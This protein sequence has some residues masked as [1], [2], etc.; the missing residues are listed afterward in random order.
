MKAS[1]VFDFNDPF[2]SEQRI[3]EEFV[4]SKQARKLKRN[5]KIDL[6][7]E[8]L[9]ARKELAI[10]KI[11]SKNEK[12][13]VKEIRNNPLEG[14]S[15]SKRRITGREFFRA[16]RNRGIRFESAHL[17]LGISKSLLKKRLS[18]QQITCADLMKLVK[19]HLTAAARTAR[20]ALGVSVGDSSW[21]AGIDW[22]RREKDGLILPSEIRAMAGA[23]KAADRS[24]AAPSELIALRQQLCL[25]GFECDRLLGQTENWWG[26]RERGAVKTPRFYL[27]SLRKR[28][29]DELD[30]P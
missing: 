6:F 27:D 16:L 10:E 15:D 18:E 20:K 17:H 26:N 1:Q 24:I 9:E 11:Q 8:V 23:L 14:L 7:F 21:L 13:R 22:S 5:A 29:Y 2:T 28:Y 30:R 3:F 19:G 4:R 12:A 25:S